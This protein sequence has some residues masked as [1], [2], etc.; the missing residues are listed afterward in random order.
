[1]SV[2]SIDALASPY[3]I[4]PFPASP[5]PRAA[6]RSAPRCSAWS[7]WTRWR[8]RWPRRRPSCRRPA[9]E[10]PLLK[11]FEENGRVLIAAHAR[12]I[13]HDDPR[14]GR[15][16][17]AE[18]LADNFH[19]VEEILREVRHDLPPG[20][21]G[22]LPKLA[23][24]P[25]T[26]YPRVYA[27]AAALVAHTDS[28][29]D[30]ARITRFVQ[31]FQ[32]VAPLT[33]GELW[34]LPTMLR[35]VLI[36]NLRRLAEQMVWGWD[37]RLRAEAFAAEVMAIG[38]TAGGGRLA[39]P[40]PSPSDPS[41]PFVVRVMQLLRDQGPSSALDRLEADLESRGSTRTRP[42]A[43]STAARPRIRSPSAIA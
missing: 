21:D 17:D 31:A 33:I 18:W 14:E 30:E 11:R 12:I 28:E 13:A 41:D 20:Y 42:C 29:Q 5:D 26:G 34:A 10:A 16:T 8:G 1:M 37:E 9:G 3:P 27:M 25:L 22:E 35:L 36:E 6:G 15:G 38:A 19:I 7:D 2:S 40:L 32:E 24:S 43:A 39:P 4:S 23:A